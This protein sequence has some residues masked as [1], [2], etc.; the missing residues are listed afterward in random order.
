LALGRLVAA[1][2]PI[3]VALA[4]ASID[5]AAGSGT[6][7][8]LEGFA[9]ALGAFTADGREGPSAFREKRRPRWTGR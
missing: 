4:K 8:A 5:G 3:A 9:G 6:V 2:P 1:H 7:L